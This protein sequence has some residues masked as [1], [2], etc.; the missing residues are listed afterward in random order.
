MAWIGN[1]IGLQNPPSKDLFRS[2]KAWRLQHLV[3]K[4]V[5]LA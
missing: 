5:M 1:N 3:L 2:S 4:G